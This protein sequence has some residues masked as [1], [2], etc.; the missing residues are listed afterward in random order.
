LLD[1]LPLDVLEDMVRRAIE[2]CLDQRRLDQVRVAQEAD[3]RRIVKIKSAVDQL[4]GQ[5]V[6]E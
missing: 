4:V 1:A 3:L 5:L 2:G 6:Q